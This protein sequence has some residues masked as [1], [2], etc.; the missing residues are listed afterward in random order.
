MELRSPPSPE[1]RAGG[2]RRARRPH[3]LTSVKV[4]AACGATTGRESSGQ[5]SEQSSSLSAA[6]GDGLRAGAE[7]EGWS[8]EAGSVAGE[9]SRRC[10]GSV[11][12]V[13]RGK[14]GKG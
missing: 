11:S 14:G 6:R 2:A 8:G 3:T 1:Y 5:Q 4:D 12:E 13:E 9:A 10:L 7:G